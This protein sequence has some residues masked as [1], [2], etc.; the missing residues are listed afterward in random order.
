V[1]DG[2]TIHTD[3]VVVAEFQEF[4]AS[5]LGAIIG[6]DGV[7]TPNLWMM[8]VKNDTSYSDLR[9]VIGRASIHFKNFSTT[10]NRWV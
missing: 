10:T 4:P 8:S 7:R 6:D 3:V 9:L 1:R 5:E 2:R